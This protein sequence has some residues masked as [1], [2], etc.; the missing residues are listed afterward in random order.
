MSAAP[1]GVEGTM[2]RSGRVGQSAAL[3]G[4][5]ELPATARTSAAARRHGVLMGINDAGVAARPQ[6]AVNATEVARCGGLRF[7][8]RYRR[9]CFAASA[10]EIA[11]GRGFAGGGRGHD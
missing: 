1:P 6:A 4:P 8:L 5:I 11:H 3:A 7:P 10:L 9:R 2:M